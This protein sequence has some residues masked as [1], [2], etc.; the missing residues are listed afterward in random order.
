MRTRC[1]E[2]SI[3]ISTT[4]T[5]RELISRWGRIRPS[6]DPFS[7]RKWDQSWPCPRSVDYTTATNDGPPETECLPSF[8][9]GVGK[10][11]RWKQGK[12]NI[13]VAK[14]LTRGPPGKR[15]NR[16]PTNR[17]IRFSTTAYFILSC[18]IEFSVGTRQPSSCAGH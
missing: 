18:R 4:I 10:Y 7:H 1:V 11:R 3:R 14:K 8:N 17:M 16:G 12:K 13:G 15:S 2:P 6:P 9:I 5:D